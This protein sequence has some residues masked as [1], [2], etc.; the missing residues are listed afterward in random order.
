MLQKAKY[1]FAHNK[2]EDRADKAT[3]EI[4]L[5]SIKPRQALAIIKEDDY[6]GEILIK[7]KV[8]AMKFGCFS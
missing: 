7:V 5:F 8:L 3:L 6:I 1:D 4:S 2:H